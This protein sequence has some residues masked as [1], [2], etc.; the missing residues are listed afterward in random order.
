MQKSF[1]Q[2]MV[3]Q[4]FQ[5]AALSHLRQA[6]AVMLLVAHKRR[7]VPGKFLKHSRHGSGANFEVAGYRVARHRPAFGTAQLPNSL[8]VIVY[9]FGS[10]RNLL[11]SWH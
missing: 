9:G 4:N 3:P 11:F 7:P 8:Q 5:S 10:C 2:T 1:E 6:N